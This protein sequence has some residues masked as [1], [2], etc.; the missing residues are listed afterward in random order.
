MAR[1]KESDSAHKGRFHVLTCRNIT[2]T[3]ALPANSL[4]FFGLGTGYLIYG[5]QELLGF[6]KR[7]AGVDFGTGVGGIWMPGVLPVSH[8]YLPLPRAHPLRHLHRLTAA[9]HGGARLGAS[10]P[11][12]SRMGTSRWGSSTWASVSG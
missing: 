4:G 8:R 2:A 3:I 6:P 5:P 7:D 10:A 1:H 11:G 9:V 12:R